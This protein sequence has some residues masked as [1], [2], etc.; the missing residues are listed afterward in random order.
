MKR[1]IIIIGLIV[2]IIVVSS[3]PNNY[4]SNAEDE[5]FNYA[6]ALQKAIMFYEFQRSGE[7]SDDIRNNWRGD[8]GLND[9]ADVG[10]DLTGGWYDAGDHVK[11]NLPMAYTTSMLAWTIY[12]EEETLKELGQ[13]EYLK[14]EIKVATDYFIKCHPSKYVYYYQ[15]GDGNADHAWWGP[16]EVMQMDRPAHKVTKDNPGSC[17]VGGTAAALAAASIVFADSDPEY[18]ELC[19]KHAKELF[20]F[21]D[22]TRSDEGY[23][24]ANGFYDSWSGYY[25]EL[26]WAATWL[27]LSTNDN[28]YLRKAEELNKLCSGE[29]TWTQSWDD[30]H[31]GAELL[32]AKIT[33]KDIY[34]NKV[35][36]Y[37]DYWTTGTSDGERITY[38]PD[39]LAWLDQWG[40][41]RYATTTAFLASIYADWDKCPANK[42]KVYNDFAKEQVD[43][44]L[45]S[46]GRSYVVGFGE[47]SPKH[48]HHRT[49]H[50]SWT[51]NLE[52]PSNHRHTLVGALVGGPDSNDN[53]SDSVSDYV[54]NEVACDYN[55]GFVGALTKMYANYGGTGISDLNAIEEPSEEFF[56]EAS[57]N[58]SS[59]NFVE[60]RAFLYNKSA[61]PAR[62]GDKLSFRYFVDLT[63]IYENG[64]TASDISITSGYSQGS[65]VSEL[66]P[67]NED[68]HIY[69][70]EID[71]SGTKIYP[72]GQSES[73][74]ETQFRLL[75]PENTSFWDSDNDPSFNNLTASELKKTDYIPVYDDGDL[76]YG[77]E[78]GG[79]SITYEKD[80]NK[81]KDN[82]EK[83][84][85]FDEVE[86]KREPEVL[87]I[88]SEREVYYID[89]IKEEPIIILADVFDSKEVE[90][91]NFILDGKK[92]AEDNNAPYTLE[93]NVVDSTK[94]DRIQSYKITAEVDFSDGSS[95]FSDDIVVTILASEYKG[96]YELY[97]YVNEN[98]N[99]ILDF[100][101]QY[102]YTSSPFKFLFAYFQLLINEI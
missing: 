18:A 4:Y 85:G 7:L 76:I 23:T 96:V 17:V 6:E 33:G 90:R 10:L 9:G 16:A 37:L 102:I 53:Y 48:P 99:I 26:T 92:V 62:V 41:L 77:V 69:F 13:L 73:K 52:E 30:V 22:E 88:K 64:Y 21:A 84:E 46:T 65:K 78:P 95:S 60:I 79:G 35:E 94:L 91:V 42:K 56:V 14:K 24:A 40:S 49:A 15:V 75:A 1:G 28:S 97:R 44:A 36:K 11:F 38:T 74:R 82:I 70:V 32:L 47:D 58:A 87:E 93:W 3:F 8:S 57:I 51:N 80:E 54:S 59:S 72:G 29:Y 67:W 83:E 31:Y 43:Y 68:K 98:I 34:K 81:D 12:E 27:Y 100:W 45:G 63:E 66:K 19:L 89:D 2:A 25:D 39:G 55:A 101:H 50:G 61:W 71:F 20:E 86:E 5:D